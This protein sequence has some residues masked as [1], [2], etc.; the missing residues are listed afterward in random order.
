LRIDRFFA[1]FLTI[2]IS[3]EALFLSRSTHNHVRRAA[4]ISEGCSRRSFTSNS[5]GAISF[6]KI[7]KPAIADENV[8]EAQATAPERPNY[9]TFPVPTEWGIGGKDYYADAARVVAHMQYATQ[10]NSH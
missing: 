7:V 1:F 6:V 8:V 5:I 2:L 9:G 10:V 4:V 3:S